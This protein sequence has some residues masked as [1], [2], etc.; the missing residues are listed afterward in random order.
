[1]ALCSPPSAAGMYSRPA[2]TMILPSA[3]QDFCA[4]NARASET[5]TG[6]RKAMA[7]TCLWRNATIS[8]SR[9]EG[10]ATAKVFTVSLSVAKRVSVAMTGPDK[11]KLRAPFPP[12]KC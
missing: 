5:S 10:A 6:S 7:M 11:T 2:R 3:C 8:I 4:A 12:R 1:M 9:A